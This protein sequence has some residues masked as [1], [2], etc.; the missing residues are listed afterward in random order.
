M[1]ETAGSRAEAAVVG[2]V[3]LGS[4]APDMVEGVA[5]VAT[6]TVGSAIDAGTEW[7]VATGPVVVDTGSGSIVVVG[8]VAIGAG[9]GAV[10]VL[11]VVVGS[12]GTVGC[13]AGSTRLSS[14]SSSGL[15]SAVTLRW[16]RGALAKVFAAG[17]RRSCKRSISS[18]SSVTPASA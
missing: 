11:A 14:A 1:D 10:V 6:M 7:D 3:E 9:A 16:R 15:S 18:A 12:V 4:G 17:I 13:D 5:V 2:D 8:V